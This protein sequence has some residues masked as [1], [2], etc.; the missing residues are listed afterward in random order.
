MSG[1]WV[2]DTDT[3][4]IYAL[5]IAHTPLLTARNDGK[6]RKSQPPPAAVTP[7]AEDS[8]LVCIVE[9]PGRQRP[10]QGPHSTRP[11]PLPPPR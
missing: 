7:P 8:I 5:C 11:P 4:M 2:L 3:I 10:R 9:R 1:K 6:L